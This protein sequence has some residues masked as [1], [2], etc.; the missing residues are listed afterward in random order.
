MRGSIVALAVG[1]VAA[2]AS[3]VRADTN[4]LRFTDGTWHGTVV[5][6]AAGEFGG[7]AVTAQA[8]LQNATFESEVSGGTMTGTFTATGEGSAQIAGGSGTLAASIDGLM[9]GTGDAPVID[10]QSA[11]FSGSATV[12]GISVPI[13]LSFG[14]GELS[15]VP[16]TITAATCTQVNGNFVQPVQS[17]VGGAGGNLTS[18]TANFFAVRTALTT[19]AAQALQELMSA[20]QQ[21]SD[22]F[23][24]TGEL[25]YAGL[26]DVVTKAEAFSASLAKASSCG[27]KDAGKFNNALTSIVAHMLDLAMESPDP[28]STDQ[29]TDLLWVGTQVGAIGEGAL[30]EAFSQKILGK[31]KT[32]ISD[33][34]TAAI[35]AGDKDAIFDVLVA[36]TTMGWT[37][38]TKQ[39][40]DA[41]GGG[42]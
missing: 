30:D 16:L 29:L 39:A 24:E 41:L 27:L 1:V 9:T 28:L 10:P 25:D 6:S 38:L 20:A 36:A 22:K 13:D 34:L 23:V 11:S 35:S 18:L 3:V 5:Y 21:I 14:A 37:D 17:A 31:A 33:R 26:V 8:A 2:S 12:Q 32:I 4:L 19:D 7:G 40:K 42:T 15:D